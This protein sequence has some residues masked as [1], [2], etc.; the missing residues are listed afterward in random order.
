MPDE[1]GWILSGSAE[2]SYAVHRDVLDGRSAWLMEPVQDTFGKYGTWMRHI[3]AAPYRGKRVQLTAAIKTQGA[4]QRVDFWGRAQA[5]DS[6]AD[7]HG[8]GGDGHKLPADS[9]WIDDAIAF[10]VPADAAFLEYGIGIAGPGRIWLQ[11]VKVDVVEQQAPAPDEPRKTNIRGWILGGDDPAEYAIT[12]DSTIKRAGHGSGSLRS[13]VPQTKGFG[14]LMQSIAPDAYLNKRVR[15]SAFVKAEN[16]TGWSGLWLRVDGKEARSSIAFDNM[17]SRPIK[18]T[19][20][21]AR[22]EV[23]LDVAKEATTIAF[24][25][26][27]HG[28]GQVWIDDMSL[29]VVK[30]SVP[31]TGVSKPKT[32]ENLDF[33]R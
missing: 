23:V 6:P 21:W 16:V 8:L 12:V 25:V 32:P 1:P 20:D 11:Q 29:E 33:E 28:G 19:Q 26:L 31:T 9:T 4:T 15:L 14:T 24:G 2:K 30:A 27:L 3:D 5:A 22:Y 18:G 13:L 7:G 17:Q 10:D